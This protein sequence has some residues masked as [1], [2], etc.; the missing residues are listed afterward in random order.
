M[1]QVE[2][3]TAGPQL[4]QPETTES[5]QSQTNVAEPKLLQPGTVESQPS[6]SIQTICNTDPSPVKP[7][8]QPDPTF[9]ETREQ[10][11]YQAYI[12]DSQS[13]DSTTDKKKEKPETIKKRF[14]LWYRRFAYC[15][16]EKLQYLYKVTDLK[17]RIQILSS[18]KRSLY[19][20]CKLSKLQ[21]RICKELSPWKETILE[22]ISV[23]VY[24]LLPKTL[25]GNKY[26]GQ[27]VDNTTCKAWVIP[28]KSRTDLV[29]CLQIWKINIERQTGIQIGSIQIDNTAELKSLLQE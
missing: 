1:Q 7:T 27:I 21:N 15:N 16:P 2:S 14:E 25:R 19:K 10:Y 6:R 26:F 29:Q 20:V 9:V 28:A 11:N 13:E 24:R 18:T 4:L 3:V 23:D 17:E 12:G 5:Q 8:R 22:L